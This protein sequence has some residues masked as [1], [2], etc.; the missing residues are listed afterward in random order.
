MAFDLFLFSSAPSTAGAIFHRRSNVFCLLGC[1]CA[2]SIYSIYATLKR[3]RKDSQPLNTTL[4]PFAFVLAQDAVISNPVVTLFRRAERTAGFTV[5]SG[6]VHLLYIR[7]RFFSFL[8]IPCATTQTPAHA[9]MAHGFHTRSGRHI[10]RHQR[11]STVR[12]FGIRIKSHH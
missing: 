2:A 5:F 11:R 4:T 10:R 1:M 8:L 6:T 9:H 12:V 3:W 7:I